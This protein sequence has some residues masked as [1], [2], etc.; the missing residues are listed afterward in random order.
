ML[1][2]T[3]VYLQADRNFYLVHQIHITFQLVLKKKNDT[4]FNFSYNRYRWE[5]QMEVSLDLQS[6]SST[7]LMAED[8]YYSL[9][10]YI[11]TNIFCV[12]TLEMLNFIQL[13]FLVYWNNLKIT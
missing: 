5:E 7:S 13:I 4:S 10:N 1:V 2:I 3:K 11:M 6:N 8:L 12:G 9:F